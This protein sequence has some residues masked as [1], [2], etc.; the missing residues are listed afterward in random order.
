MRRQEFTGKTTQEALDAG[1]AAIPSESD[2]AQMVRNVRAWHRARP[3]DWTVCWEKI[4]AAYSKKYN[5][6]LR[7]SNGGI[8]VRLN[9][10]WLQGPAGEVRREARL[11]AHV[12]PYGVQPAEAR[13][14]LRGAR[15]SAGPRGLSV[16]H[17][18]NF[19][20]GC[21]DPPVRR[22]RRRS[23]DKARVPAMASLRKT[24][25]RTAAGRIAV[26]LIFPL[27]F[28][29]FT[30]KKRATALAVALDLFREIPGRQSAPQ[31]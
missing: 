16:P 20:P 19:S 5:K 31:K 21:S 8:D 27:I 23:I 29:I 14:R 22:I 24:A 18:L 2:Y 10:A 26:S 30:P 6:D 3:D 1:L 13:R 7:D 12:H 17:L 11:V 25:P 15:R 28:P 4:R 9:G